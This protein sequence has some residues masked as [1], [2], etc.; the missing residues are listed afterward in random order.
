M[1]QLQ[2]NFAAWDEGNVTTMVTVLYLWRKNW[3]EMLFGKENR[4]PNNWLA[5]GGGSAV[6][7]CY[8][9][10]VEIL[11]SQGNYE[12]NILKSNKTILQ[13]GCR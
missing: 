3:M 13:T 4:L 6:A 7:F 5:R 9:F 2:Q 1:L 11:N 10:V 8:S 12:D